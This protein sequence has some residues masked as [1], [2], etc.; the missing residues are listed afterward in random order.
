MGTKKPHGFCAVGL[1]RNF[2]LLPLKNVMRAEGTYASS[3]MP[4]PSVSRVEAS[5]RPVVYST[6]VLL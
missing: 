4:K 3:I 1:L 5:V 2:R 6:T